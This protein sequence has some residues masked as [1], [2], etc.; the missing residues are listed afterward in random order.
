MNKNKNSQR[1][2]AGI[3]ALI[4][5]IPLCLFAI[6]CLLVKEFVLF[7]VFGITGSLFIYASN[8]LLKHQVDADNHCDQAPKN[9]QIPTPINSVPQSKPKKC[10]VPQVTDP[11]VEQ[12]SQKAIDRQAP[13]RKAD[14]NTSVKRTY[15][16]AGTTF[17]SDNIMNLA[18]GN[19]DYELS[20]KELID[21]DLINER[22]WEYEFDP[23]DVQ[24]I[25]E[26]DNPEDPN[27]IKVIVDGEHVGYIK[28]GSCAHLL[29]VIREGRIAG[30]T[31]EMGGGKYKYISTEYDDEND[32]DVYTLERDT[33][34]FFVHLEIT[35]LK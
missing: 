16:V 28:A 32:K 29:K 31:C 18:I 5:G 17:H 27:A 8:R 11:K 21:D 22:I 10:A 25:H 14:T 19:S 4:A 3:L 24:L 26:P 30:I 13:T 1:K 9:T 7:L 15:R 6:L 34:P 20:K 2:V 35:E 33:C 23:S 12:D